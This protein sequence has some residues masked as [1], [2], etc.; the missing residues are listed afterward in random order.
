M[1]RASNVEDDGNE[2]VK[3][4]DDERRDVDDIVAVNAFAAGVGGGLV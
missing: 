4:Y 1:S 2:C 3:V